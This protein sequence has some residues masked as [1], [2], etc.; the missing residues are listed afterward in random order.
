MQYSNL[1]PRV[2]TYDSG[3]EVF[4]CEID[5]YYLDFIQGDNKKLIVTFEPVMADDILLQPS[6]EA[7]GLSFLYKEGF[8]VLGVKSKSLDW[9]RG[10]ELHKYFR[11]ILPQNLFNKFEKI[12]FYGGSMGGYGC[13]AFADSY[14]GSIVIS[15]APQSTLSKQLVPWEKR[16]KKGQEQDWSGD[17]IDGKIGAYKASKVYEF[18][19]PFTT[20][21]KAHI[22]RLEQK[23]VVRLSLPFMGHRIP[24]ALLRM[25]ILK[26]VVLQAINGELTKETFKRLSVTRRNLPGYYTS[27]ARRSNSLDLKKFCVEKALLCSAKS[28]R[29]RL[30]IEALDEQLK[31]CIHTMNITNGIIVANLLEFAP[32]LPRNV[33]IF[34]RVAKFYVLINDLRKARLFLNSLEPQI[35]INTS[36]K[37]Q[38][39]ILK[40][41]RDSGSKLVVRVKE[42]QNNI[43]TNEIS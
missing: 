40:F 36:V 6:R 7:W 12:V 4:Q 41:A 15:M 35:V 2:I 8:S 29:D 27:M 26:E 13:L 43:H 38:K 17:F 9:F 30:F 5:G 24:A 19:D 18:Y 25:G 33:A 32:Q 11:D 14:P 37:V 28:L 16:F 1:F 23:N 20:G 39:E 22:D 10:K 31:L 3:L 21:D 34:S 42:F